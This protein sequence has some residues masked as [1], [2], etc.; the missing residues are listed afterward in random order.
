MPISFFSCPVGFFLFLQKPHGRPLFLPCLLLL[1]LSARSFPSIHK[2]YHLYFQNVVNPLAH[3]LCVT[4]G[5]WLSIPSFYQPDSGICHP[6][7]GWQCLVHRLPVFHSHLLFVVESTPIVSCRAPARLRIKYAVWK[8]WLSLLFW[9]LELYS[10]S[11]L[12][13]RT[14]NQS[15]K[16]YKK[17]LLLTI[18]SLDKV[19]FALTRA[20]LFSLLPFS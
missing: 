17:A 7:L 10:L 1:F 5:S 18:P 15:S 3:P 8:N 2:L 20:N 14:L 19:L 6:L 13:F 11:S 16:T 4:Q 9:L 12:Y